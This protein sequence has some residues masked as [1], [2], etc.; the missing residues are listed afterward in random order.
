MAVLQKA[1][2]KKTAL[3]QTKV[4]KKYHSEQGWIKKFRKGGRKRGKGGAGLVDRSN[5]LY[6]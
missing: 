2:T 1:A 3:L 4:N 6:L 5:A